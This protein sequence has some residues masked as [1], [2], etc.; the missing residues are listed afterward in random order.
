MVRHV[1][2]GMDGV[3]KY[4]KY[5]V[6]VSSVLKVGVLDTKF[7]KKKSSKNVELCRIIYHRVLERLQ[8]SIRIRIRIPNSTPNKKPTLSK[9][10]S[11]FLLPS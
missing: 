4:I 10:G 6:P 7:T 3:T 2:A 1:A 9:E 8:F 11:E 5:I